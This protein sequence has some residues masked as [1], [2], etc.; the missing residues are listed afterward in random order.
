MTDNA[1][2]TRFTIGEYLVNTDDNTV[3]FDGTA[4][5]IEPRA[6]QVLQVLAAQANKTVNRQ[7][8]L[9]QVW[10]DR[11]VV[12]EAL[13]RTISQLRNAFNDSKSRAVIQTVPKKGYR[14]NAAVHWHQEV[15]GL[16]PPEVVDPI[17]PEQADV[18]PLTDDVIPADYDSGKGGKWRWG[19]PLLI[20]MAIIGVV[21]W[22]VQSSDSSLLDEAPSVAVLPLTSA[23]GEE[24]SEYLAQGISEE[25]V[26]AL[27]RVGNLRVPSRYSTL[28]SVRQHTTVESLAG[29]LDVRFLL[30]GSV[31][32]A[33]GRFH[34]TV[35]LIDATKDATV[36]SNTY[37]DE[38]AHLLTI[39]D[40]V[41]QDVLT[42]LLPSAGT[43]STLGSRGQVSNVDAYQALLKGNYWLMNGSTSD[44][45]LQAE[46]AF[47]KAIEEDPGYARAYGSLAYIYARYDYH[48]RHL[49]PAKA[50]QLAQ[51]AIDTALT[52]DPNDTYAHLARAILATSAQR[53]TAAEKAL[54][55]V[56]QHSPSHP[57]ALYLYS[58]LRLAQNQFD[59]AQR[60][61]ELALE[62]DPYSPW[63]N[64]NQAI[65]HFWRN[66]L[67]AALEATD[68]AI[69]IDEKYT[70]AYVWK[71]KILHQMGRLPEA[72]A[73]MQASL[74][75]DASSP[76]N[77]AYAG[78]LY[79][80]LGLPDQADALFTTTASLLGDGTDA[81]L[82][83]G[84]VRFAYQ[85]QNPDVA[86]ALL[87][88]S[89][90]LD[91][92]IFSLVPV[93][94]SV[95]RQLG[96]EQK[97]IEV[98]QQPWPPETAPKVNYLN[99]HRMAGIAALRAGAEITPDPAPVSIPPVLLP[100]VTGTYA[101]LSDSGNAAQAR[102]LLR[103]QLQTRWV[104]FIWSAG[105]GW[106]SEMASQAPALTDPLHTFL[107]RRQ[108][109]AAKV[110]NSE[111]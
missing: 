57:S 74:K 73:V 21:A 38:N 58:E 48:D 64:V 65:V 69:A 109:A 51:T 37:E 94:V 104:P 29:A 92:R 45:F 24:K 67:D 76:V 32:Q 79:L 11:V 17:R 2:S 53:F 6:M 19:L 101:M 75:Q 26:T 97:A 55:Q 81:R 84:F 96:E 31:Q 86:A 4:K 44:W 106:R 30:E 47:N 88:E 1:E 98:L 61:A 95:Y 52:L 36:W 13:T 105:S 15:A 107:Q 7:A 39:S 91:N 9:E 108:A 40:T 99:L 63:I 71:A 23:G 82:W 18:P 50:R 27:G 12:D 100:K 28:A 89:A 16:A 60:Y 10:G 110:M 72:I 25:L 42:V 78:L 43:A 33:D 90:L 20:V 80:E 102:T 22:L 70:W 49:A 77:T 35:R 54:Q 41:A 59:T 87:A 34:I 83:K 66:E 3:T 56:L 93:L 85:Q 103:E 46:A 62:A 5:H 8:L 14:L 68:A 111:H